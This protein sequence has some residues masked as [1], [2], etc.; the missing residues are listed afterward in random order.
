MAD[1]KKWC[2]KWSCLCSRT[3]KKEGFGLIH[4][5]DTTCQNENIAMKKVL[6]KSY[7]NRKLSNLISIHNFK[8]IRINMNNREKI[9]LTIC[10][11]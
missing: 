7:Y 10:T 2:L 4:N 6:S 3:G 5:S 9:I 1:Y 8:S 11:M